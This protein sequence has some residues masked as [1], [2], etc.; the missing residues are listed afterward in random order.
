LIFAGFIKL[1]YYIATVVGLMALE[2][3]GLYVF[4]HNILAGWE[5]A[6]FFY[7]LMYG[8]FP[9]SYFIWRI[10]TAVSLKRL[11]VLI[12]VGGLINFVALMWRGVIYYDILTRSS[13]HI[14]HTNYTDLLIV[15]S[16]APNLIV[17]SQPNGRPHSRLFF[18][19]DCMQ[20]VLLAYLVYMRLFGVIPFTPEAVAPVSAQTMTILMCSIN[21]FMLILT[22]LRY[23]G[24]MTPDE[25][26]FFRTWGVFSA[27]SL[28]LITLYNSVTGTS[29]TATYNEL[30]VALSNYIG[31][32]LFLALPLESKEG[33]LT[34][35]S[36]SIAEILNIV[37][38]AFFTLALLA[39]GIDAARH[40]FVFGMGAIAVAFILHMIRSTILQ[41]IY[42][43]SQQ[44][45]QAARDQL[46]T[47]S[48]TDGLTGVANRRCFDRTLESEWN[49]AVRTGE[50]LSLMMIDI[51]YFKRLNDRYGHQAGDNCLVGVARALRG[52]LPRSG[53]LLARYGGEEFAVILPN[54][55]TEGTS[56]V[57]EKMQEA[58]RGLAVENESSIGL[59][60]T[61]SIGVATHR[62]PTNFTLLQL[63]EETDKALY[64]AKENG[65]NRVEVASMPALLFS[66]PPAKSL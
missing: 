8:V 50:S 31:F 26:R 34:H 13:T 57:A 27:T 61:L 52:C 53:D 43:R 21:V 48:L 14:L 15:L 36:S 62:F 54:T 59:Y 37:C 56:V 40:Y 20:I 7:F 16:L 38:P 64:G 12:L 17:L 25:R 1:R 3:L 58:V 41:K 32:G 5:L 65:R 42:E 10:R 2:V 33:G 35:R 60:V 47:M 9:I 55:N 29:D 23:L 46:E 18:W 66:M 24:G 49:R 4:R 19:V 39:M 30:L 51:D 11:W 22:V 28:C 63:L 44:A 45:L 6:Y